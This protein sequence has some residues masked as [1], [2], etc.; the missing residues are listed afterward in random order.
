PG[1]RAL[2]LTV[3]ALLLF[4]VGTNVQAGWLIVLAS[5]LVGSV[6]V[7][8]ILP[9][10]MVRG[11]RVER[12][13]PTEAFQGDEV[14]VDLVVEG[15]RRGVRLSLSVRDPNLGPTTV[16]VPV[17]RPGE[18]TTLTSRRPALRRG[19]AEPC[20]MTISSSAPFGVARATRRANSTETTMVY[21]R[22]VPLRPR[23][24]P[25]ASAQA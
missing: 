20:P 8:M 19:M 17:L 16:F 12:R 5:L 11:V 18:R 2:G 22:L 7:G 9:P 15:A 10:F 6:L 21:P 24:L 4:A 1:R 14:P 23:R 3:G 13:A 25:H